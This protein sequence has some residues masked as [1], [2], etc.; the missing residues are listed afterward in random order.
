PVAFDASTL[1][2][3]GALL[4]GAR[5]VLAPPHTPSLDE[6]AALLTHHRVSTLWLTAA[7]FEQMVLHQGNALAAVRQVL[8]GG[9]VLPPLRVRQH[10]ERIPLGAVLVNGYGPTEN[11]TF[12]ATHSLR[13]GE[14]FGTSVP[15]GRPLGHSS[16]FVLDSRMEPVP[17]GVPG[18]LFVGGDGLA[19]GYLNRPEL[20]AEKFLPHPFS[21]V[22]GARLYRTGDRVR[23]KPD[24]SLDFLGRSDFQVKVRGFRIELGEIEAVLQQAPGVQEAVVLAREDA[25]GDKRLVAY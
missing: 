14:A 12:S 5:L 11:T 1:E 17:V 9:D 20:T 24:G 8:A 2:L 7:L 3:W 25:P 15:I 19:W 21:S 13:A 22:P 16:A 4:H 23:W 18:E 6:L 10:L